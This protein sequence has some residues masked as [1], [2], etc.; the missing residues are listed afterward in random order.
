[1]QIREEIEL[2]LFAD[3]KIINIENP[4]KFTKTFRT[5]KRVSGRSW[6]TSSTHTKKINYI[7][8]RN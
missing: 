5:N 7:S 8:Y 6:D 1:M 3:N 4:K 2:S